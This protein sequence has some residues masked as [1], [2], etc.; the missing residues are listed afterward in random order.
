MST[1]G[2][3]RELS[4]AAVADAVR[5]DATL[6]PQRKQDL[7]SALNTCSRVLGVPLDALPCAPRPIGTMM[8]KAKPAACGVS[9]RRW[10]N[11]RSLIGKAL[12]GAGP[13]LPA[14]QRTPLSSDW[15]ALSGALEPRYRRAAIEAGLRWLSARQI[16][17]ESVTTGDLRAYLESVRIESLRKHPEQV[18]YR[19]IANWNHACAHVDGWPQAPLEWAS[20]RPVRHLP[21]SA[22]PPSLEADVEAFLGRQAAIDPMAM[23]GPPQP[24][25]PETL[26]SYRGVLRS[27]AWSLVQKGVARE[28]LRTLADLVSLD[29]FRL[30]LS[31]VWARNGGHANKSST[32]ERRAHMLI[33]VARH[34]VG[35]DEKTL[36]DM[37]KIA[38]RLTPETT[39]L[40][41]KN[42]ARLQPF[43]STEFVRRALEAPFRLRA[44]VDRGRMTAVRAAECALRAAAIA[45]LLVAPM[46]IKNLREIEIGKHL[47]VHGDQLTL[48]F[49][50]HEVKNSVSL[51]FALDPQT[52]DLVRWYIEK[53]RPLLNPA[54][55][56]FLFPGRKGGAR[57][58]CGMSDPI[59][60]QMRKS[61]GVDF[62]PHLFRHLSAKIFLDNNPG[63]FE[64]VRQLLGHKSIVTT[65]R[66]YAEFDST[67]AAKLYRDVVTGLRAKEGR[68]T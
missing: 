53:H 34:Y 8:A 40:T 21:W 35:A 43:E 55:S 5:A 9:D 47:R 49:D 33:G 28:S 41:A 3:S 56:Q 11:V 2:N 13:L 38:K 64:T 44:S 16:G 58:E 62:N 19:F 57:S 36:A 15:A 29:N 6:A 50:P 7:L 23:D 26:K 30:G 12:A 60:R 31:E 25:R 65:M 52:A 4:L 37:K 24:L 46:R 51:A 54:G 45:I 10:A 61:L 18:C 20:R 48:T 66:F 32:L 39:G 63:Q 42:R 22:Y 17:P 14:R 68:R 27:F 67:V 1:D 59:K